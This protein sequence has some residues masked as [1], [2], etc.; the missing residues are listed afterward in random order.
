MRVELMSGRRWRRLSVLVLMLAAGLSTCLASCEPNAGS[1]G[2]NRTGYITVSGGIK[3]A[4]DLTLPAA[5]GRFPVAVEYNDYTAGADNSA[6]SPGSDAGRLLAAGFAVLG[7]NMPGSGCSGGIN[8]VTD[9]KEWG[10]AGAQAVEWAAAQKWSTGHVGMFGSSQTGISQLGVASFRP[11]GLDAITPFHI[12]TDYYRDVAYPGGV[13]NSKFMNFYAKYLVTIDKQTAEPAIKTGDRQ[14]L[15]DFRAHVRANPPYSIGRNSLANPF[16]DGYWQTAPGSRL[17]RIGVP[18]LGCQSWQ[19]GVVSSRATELY[20][21]TFS[22]RRTWFIGTNGPH[23]ICEF[24]QPLT[25]MVNFLRHYVAGANDGWQQTPHITIL[26]ELTSTNTSPPVPGWVTTYDSWSQLMKPVTLY[27]RGHGS[28]AA[29]PVTGGT[30]GQSSFSGPAPSQSGRWN[31][32]PPPGTS[33]SYTT[34]PLTGDADIFGPGSVNLW[35]S[36]TAADSDIEV[37]ISEVRPDG[38]EQFVQAGWL[39]LAERKLAPAGDGPMGSSVLRPLQLHTAASYQPLRPGGPV[40]ARV[41]LFPFEHVFR[42]G[43]SIRI[44]IDS[45]D[46]NLETTGYWGVTSLAG[47]FADTIYASPARPSDVVL[48]L[49]PGA[50]A[51]R[52]LP[53]CARIAGEPCRPNGTPVPHGSLTTPGS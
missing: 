33:V 17:N 4:Y 49:I 46:G 15:K 47:Q 22:A 19:D 45:A 53:S 50:T 23:G 10:R 16:D 28:L 8:N 18:I 2:V 13:F 37:I 43:S 9:V 29:S 26:H 31:K 32:A 1:S 6:E 42:T 30:A 48:G 5:A 7:V 3:L 21:G 11:K 27:F 24:T 38:T 40:Y 14:C 20:D 25:M 36:S 52:P 44:T 39:N 41:E 35:L 51:A 34:P 12:A